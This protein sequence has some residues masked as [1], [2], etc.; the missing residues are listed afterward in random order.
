MVEYVQI[1]PS[2]LIFTDTISGTD[3]RANRMHVGLEYQRELKNWLNVCGAFTISYLF[4]EKRTPIPL[5]NFNSY[6]AEASF[7]VEGGLQFQLVDKNKHGLLTAVG[8]AYGQS[9][10][11]SSSLPLYRYCYLYRHGHYC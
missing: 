6:D 3:P 9:F 1:N 5:A 8:V 2:G 10:S 4:P 7:Y 11:S